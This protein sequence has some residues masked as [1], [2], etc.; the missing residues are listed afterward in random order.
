M[1][2]FKKKDGGYLDALKDTRPELYNTIN[3]YRTRIGKLDEGDEK[4]TKF[5]KIANQQLAATR[6]MP[7]A[8]REAYFKSI[9]KEYAKPTDEQFEKV[10]KQVESDKRFVPAYRY[11]IDQTSYGPTKGYYR[12]LS[13]EIAD[14]QKKI[15]ELKFTGTKTRTVP[16]YEMTIPSPTYGLAGGTAPQ[17]KMTT[18]LPK[19]AKLVQ[20]Q[21]GLQYYQEPMQ[22]TQMG[23]KNTNPQYR[24][25]GSKQ[26]TEKFTRQAKA[27]D[28][29]YDKAFAE[30]GRLE[31]RHKY[32]NLYSNANKPNL[33]S[34]NVYSKL[35]M[36]SAPQGGGMLST[37][38]KQM[39]N[40]P[41]QRPPQAVGAFSKFVQPKTQPQQMNEGG[42]VKGKGKAVRGFKFSGVK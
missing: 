34:Q 30:L 26:I 28:P 31:Q 3:T 36:G 25:V 42:E 37:S 20:G 16:E 9:E 41:M 40:N 11:A 14:Q 7:A 18:E 4:V 32:R 38:Y 13:K 10:L 39:T 24:R 17:T 27:G 22:F 29:E 23:Q 8:E 21:Y 6:N 5:D 2:I 33:T 19:G 12:N 1:R 35:G 15:D